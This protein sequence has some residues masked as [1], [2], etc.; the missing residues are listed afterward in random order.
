MAKFEQ[1]NTFSTG[2]KKGSRNKL[3]NDVRG[4]LHN[5][6]DEMGEDQRDENGNP[7][8]GYQAFLKWA[9]ENQTEFY[10]MYAKMIPATAEL[11]DDMHEDFVAELVFEE[12]QGK[13]IEGNA[14]MI[15]VT[16]EAEMGN[17][18]QK[19]PQM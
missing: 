5:V 19:P 6:Y 7:L 10:R 2:R 14:K 1:G 13:L 11:A 17:G 16:D 8:T 15:D 4:C 12:E 9:R 3:S 18:S